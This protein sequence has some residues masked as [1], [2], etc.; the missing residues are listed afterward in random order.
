MATQNMVQKAQK[1]EKQPPH[2]CAAS[3]CAEKQRELYGW[4]FTVQTNPLILH[5]HKYKAVLKVS[6]EHTGAGML[7]DTPKF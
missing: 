5:R 7:M 4:C 6:P 2:S 3:Q 1:P